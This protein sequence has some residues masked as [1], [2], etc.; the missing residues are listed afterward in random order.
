MDLNSPV[1][2]VAPSLHLEVLAVLAG[3]T[4]PLTGRQVHRLLPRMAS[5]SGVRLV[6]GA[7]ATSGLVRLTEAGSANLYELNRDHVAAPAALALVDL[8][9]ELLRRIRLSFQGWHTRPLAAALFGSAARGDGDVDSDIDVF[10]V[11]P[12]HVPVD[13]ALWVRDVAALNGD[14]R[15]WSGNAGSIVEADPDQVAAMMARG[16]PIVAQLL[17]DQVPLLGSSVLDLLVKDRT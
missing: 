6:L 17:A 5:Q 13:D 8:R 4:R 7:L 14:I 16:E 9:G 11:R 2:S 10:V 12:A 3:T 15:R 1:R